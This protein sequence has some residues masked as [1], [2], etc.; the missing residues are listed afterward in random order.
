MPEPSDPYAHLPEQDADPV[1]WDPQQRRFV[2][3]PDRPTSKAPAV[4]PPSGEGKPQARDERRFFVGSG[5]V[6]QAP[7]PR[8]VDA[9]SPPAPPGAPPLIPPSPAP[10]PLPG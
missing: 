6:G 4:S 9:P 3:Q 2:P 7:P 5:A 8:D 10:S 1:E